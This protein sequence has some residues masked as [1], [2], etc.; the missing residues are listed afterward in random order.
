MCKDNLSGQND[1]KELEEWAVDNL[2]NTSDKDA[3]L[4]K[5]HSFIFTSLPKIKSRIR[6]AAS[7]ILPELAR[8][9]FVPMLTICLA[10][11]GRI[12]SILM[13]IG[14]A[15]LTCLPDKVNE[16]TDHL[17]GI[18]SDEL[19]SKLKEYVNVASQKDLVT[20][21]GLSKGCFSNADG[22]NNNVDDGHLMADTGNLVA[23]TSAEVDDEHIPLT[24][25]YKLL[26]V[27]PTIKVVDPG[28][29]YK[30]KKKKQKHKKTIKKETS[31]T[32]FDSSSK[33]NRQSPVPMN[34]E[35]ASDIG[36]SSKSNQSDTSVL[37][38]KRARYV[39][40][41]FDDATGKNKVKHKR[42]KTKKTRGSVIDDIF[43]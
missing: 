22:D 3:S 7:A 36:F 10:C 25:E 9:H 17:F 5:I 34:E 8:G 15:C 4:Q 33:G 29:T 14:R 39:D 41:N 43:S 42:K 27:K 20:R 6:H 35:A 23:S 37:S 2:E 40:G 16:C 21:F 32:S 30:K 24:D 11:L 28:G 31:D 18:G 26:S 38:G 12:N 13:H 1:K 19:D